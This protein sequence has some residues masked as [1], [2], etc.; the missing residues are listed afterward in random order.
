ME[1]LRSK[2]IHLAHANPSLR[3]HLLPLV[4]KTAAYMPNYL[5][6]TVKDLVS[7]GVGGPPVELL[8][9]LH[10]VHEELGALYVLLNKR[11]ET[12]GQV[13]DIWVKNQ[14]VTEALNVM[15]EALLLTVPPQ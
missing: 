13:R 10:T 1:N 8:R 2:I 3:P 11:D 15:F 9:A 4:S 7:M 14:R 6:A 12:R 5:L